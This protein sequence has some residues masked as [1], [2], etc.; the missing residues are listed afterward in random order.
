MKIIR[1]SVERFKRVTAAEIT[2]D[3]N[4]V[5][6]SGKNG[7]GK[8]SILDAIWLAIG[9][10]SAAKECGVS[11]PVREG[12][13]DAR[14]T[15]DLG[16]IVVTRRWKADG[17]S[18]LEITSQ[19][20]RKFSS[21]Q[22]LLDSLVGRISFDPLAF[23]RMDS[24]E[25]RRQLIDLVKLPINPDELDAKRQTL[26]DERTMVN[27]EARSYAAEL[28]G[29]KAPEPGTPDEEISVAQLMDELKTAQTVQREIN[30]METRVISMRQKAVELK[31]EIDRKQKELDGII[32]EGRRLKTELSGMKSPDVNAI[33]IKLENVAGINAAVSSKKRYY[34]V[35]GRAEAKGRE[36]E[37][38]SLKIGEIDAAKEK[39]F[40]E[41][42]MPIEGLAFEVDGISYMG[43]PF[44]QCSSA[45]QMKVCIAIAAALNPQ[46]RVIRVADA[47]LLDSDSLKYIEGLANSQDIQIWLEKVTDG[48]KGVGITIEDGAVKDFAEESAA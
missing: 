8:S 13:K 21:P 12:E 14:V 3:G 39:A 31:N 37:E 24:R 11:N 17:K 5:I 42:K 36:S 22:S 19:D 26:Y 23:A 27:R 18:T 25:Q 33:N 1:L 38:L 47:S 16:D 20:G 4:T 28:A 40:R 9:G 45:E 43:V 10:A 15:L 32:A 2:P 44:R 30:D 6:L 48:E 35:K 46:I 41:A 7:Q 34:D 29:M